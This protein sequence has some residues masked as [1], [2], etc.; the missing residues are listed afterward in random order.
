MDWKQILTSLF[1]FLTSWGI[2]LLGALVILAVGTK[3]IRSFVKWIRKSPKLDNLDKSLRTFLAS[4][5]NIVLFILLVITITSILGIPATSFITILASCGV[6]IGLALQGSLSNFAGGLMILL[7]KP[8]KVGDYIEA[9]GESG[10]VT[11]ITVVYTI[12]LTPDNKRITI[13]NGTLT[14]SV[15]EN[16]S[17]EKIR[18]VDLAFTVEYGTDIDKVIGIVS[19]VIDSHP[20]AL[21]DPAPFVRMSE[22]GEHGIKVVGR[23]WCNNGDYWTV[24]FDVLEAVKKEFDANGI[25]IPFNQLDVHLVDKK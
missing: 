6:A 19:R 23:A 15:I 4:F 1:E 11:E 13:P 8:F 2:K 12:L 16:Y 14:N 3:I 18:R 22:C 10:T 25:N 9:S 7:F 5:C 17:A 20:L 24:N 21:K